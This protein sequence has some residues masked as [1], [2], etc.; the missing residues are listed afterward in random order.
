MVAVYSCSLGGVVLEFSSECGVVVVVVVV[1]NL[2]YTE[3][4]SVPQSLFTEAYNV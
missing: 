2:R 4:C 3:W 1:V